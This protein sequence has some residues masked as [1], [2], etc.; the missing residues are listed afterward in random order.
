MVHQSVIDALLAAGV[1]LLD[2]RTTFIDE[3]VTIGAGTIVHPGVTLEGRTRVGARCRLRS[4]VRIADSDLGDDVIVND[5][6]VILESRVDDGCSVGPFAHLRPGSHM[7]RG[8]HVGN[9]VELKK[10]V[11]GEGSKASHLTY[12]GDAAI[13]AN[14]NI[15]AGTITCNYDGARKHP[16]TIGDGAFV[17]SGSQLVAPVAVGESAYVAAGSTITEDVPPGALGIARGRQRNVEG[18]A[19]RRRRQTEAPVPAHDSSASA[20]QPSLRG[21]E[22]G[23]PAEG[24]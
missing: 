7:K 2:P 4:W 20:S 22:G 24:S 18:W 16:T 21:P 11:L 14:V 17:G 6:C 15:G 19:A 23:S 5:S 10:T 3:G 8:A 12:L 1:T 13:G 9:Y